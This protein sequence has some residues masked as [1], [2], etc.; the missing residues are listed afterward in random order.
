MKKKNRDTLT[1]AG[2]IAAA[3]GMTLVL[4][5]ILGGFLPVPYLTYQLYSPNAVSN[6][7]THQQALALCAQL[8][9]TTPKASYQTA[10][11]ALACIREPIASCTRY[12]HQVYTIWIENQSPQGIC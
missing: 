5:S 2:T 4:T 7:M 6:N 8:L 3:G 10:P 12:G 1:T 9:N 11:Y